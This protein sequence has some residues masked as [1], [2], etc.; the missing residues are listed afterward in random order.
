MVMGRGSRKDVKIEDPL[1]KPLIGNLIGNVRAKRLKAGI[2]Q[3]EL[4]TK[5]ALAVNTVSEIE[6]ERI[7]DIRLSTVTALAKALGEIDPLS[8]FRKPQKSPK[9]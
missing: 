9:S 2:S 6:Q 1:L 5:A 3:Q 4:A 7:G 8:L